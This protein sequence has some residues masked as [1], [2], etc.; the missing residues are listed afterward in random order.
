MEG[1]KILL[2]GPAATGKGIFVR[3]INGKEKEHVEYN[4]GIETYPT[5]YVSNNDTKPDDSILFD[6]VLRF[7][8]DGEVIF[9]KGF[10]LDNPS[11]IRDQLKE[12]NEVA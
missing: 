2:Y 5:V 4:S 8:N 9:E 12:K 10:K 1:K 3:R 11:I 7:T 6:M